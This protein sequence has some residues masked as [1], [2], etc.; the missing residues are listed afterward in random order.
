M[1]P[2]PPDPFRGA[3]PARAAALPLPP[4]NAFSPQAPGRGGTRKIFKGFAAF[5]PLKILT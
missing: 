3:F 1:I 4:G 2:A 5:P